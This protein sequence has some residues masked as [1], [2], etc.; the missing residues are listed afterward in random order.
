MEAQFSDVEFSEILSAFAEVDDMLIG[1][2]VLM[3]PAREDETLMHSVDQQ[4]ETVTDRSS[5]I[6]YDKFTDDILTSAAAASIDVGPKP[7]NLPPL[8]PL[9]VDMVNPL[10]ASSG[11]TN[12]RS[13]E[14]HRDSVRMLQ[15]LSSGSELAEHSWGLHGPLSLQ[16]APQQPHNLAQHHL[17]EKVQRELQLVV[18]SG[19]IGGQYYPQEIAIRPPSLENRVLLQQ[20]QQQHQ[21]LDHQHAH[22]QR[23]PQQHN[24]LQQQQQQDILPEQHVLLEPP[25]PYLVQTPSSS[26]NTDQSYGSP[27]RDSMDISAEGGGGS[28][29]AVRSVVTATSNPSDSAG[30]HGGDKGCC[31]STLPISPAIQPYQAKLNVSPNAAGSGPSG[32]L[33]APVA[34]W[35]HGTLV[36]T[37]GASGTVFWAPVA[38]LPPVGQTDPMGRNPDPGSQRTPKPQAVAGC[39]RACLPAAPA[40]QVAGQQQFISSSAAAGTGLQTAMAAAALATVPPELGGP[41]PGMVA[42][43]S[44][45]AIA[46]SLAPTIQSAV[47]VPAT[48]TTTAAAP[49]H[50]STLQLHPVATAAVAALASAPAIPVMSTAT[51]RTMG[52][53]GSALLAELVAEAASGG[54]AAVATGLAPLPSST[55]RTAEELLAGLDLQEVFTPAKPS[56]AKRIRGHVRRAAELKAQ[57]ADRVRDIQRL[58]A[59]NADL[60]GRAKVL[61]LV[62]KCRDEQLRLLRNYRTSDDGRLYFVEQ[63]GLGEAQM[64]APPGDGTAAVPHI[65]V[66]AAVL[67]TMPASGLLEMFSKLFADVSRNLAAVEG[68]VETAAP[69][70]GPKPAASSRA[71]IQT[72]GSPSDQMREASVPTLTV[73][74]APKPPTSGACA[75]GGGD[76]SSWQIAMVMD[77]AVAADGG[78]D[79]G[80]SGPLACLRRQMALLRNIQRYLGLVNEEACKFAFTTLTGK[81]AVPEPGHWLRVVQSLS[82]TRQQLADAAALDSCWQDWLSRIHSER[83][84]IAS[85]LNQLLS[86]NRYGATYFESVGQ[87]GT[88][89]DAIHKMHANVMR[90]RIL[91]VLTGEVFCCHILTDLQWARAVVQSYPY[92]LDVRELSRAASQLYYS[93]IRGLVPCAA[94]S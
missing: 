11:D 88:D 46:R 31:S 78:G 39:S 51:G 23:L 1:W 72:H 44:A 57:L 38:H 83:R 84:S 48:V 74:A 68:D 29:A 87:Y 22:I 3:T 16:Y 12:V 76:G 66:N 55:G 50:L 19:H 93:S 65:G 41:G 59:E 89:R 60:R 86:V 79:S 14:Q 6:I 26:L 67:A 69:K 42:V 20:H 58:A 30:E 2:D 70:P 15:P 64:A 43:G 81:T 52:V 18:D 73:G 35:P 21:Q 49:V 63:M 7:Q 32:L 10:Q 71:A 90:E 13:P 53:S 27:A 94:Q 85:A 37:T 24:F 75:S 25:L 34:L 77:A 61:E 17:Q 4:S 82:L 56:H 5:P 91:M 80:V 33:S 54:W 36:T 8:H 62:V 40:S 9:S 28:L 45:A 92:I 47:A